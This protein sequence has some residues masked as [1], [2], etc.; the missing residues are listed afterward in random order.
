M[1]E[2][3]KNKINLKL[4]R[5]I[6][7]FCVVSVSLTIGLVTGININKIVSNNHNGNNQSTSLAD[8]LANFLK[9]NW[10]S[11]I[12]YGK[13][14][15]EDV[16]IAQFIGALSTSKDTMLDS[17][18]FLI[19]NES[20]SSTSGIVKGKLGATFTNY[21][22]LPLITK[23]EDNAACKGYLNV[24]DIVVGLSKPD[25]KNNY[26]HYSIFD[27]DITFSGL[28]EQGLGLPGQEEI[29]TIARQVDENSFKYIDYKITLKAPSYTSIAYL[30]KE[31]I[32]NTIMVKLDGFVHDDESSYGTSEQ[33][34]QIL[35]KNIAKNLILDLRGNG[36]GD[37][38]SAIDVAD[39][40]LDNDLVVASL[41]Y[42]NGKRSSY[43]SD[44]DLKY[45]YDNIVILQD[46]GT[47]SASE[48]LISALLHYLPET[49]TLVGQKSYGKGICQSTT[50][51]M[52]GKYQLKYTI[53]KWLRPDNTWIGM[54]DAF[55]DGE[56][57]FYPESQNMVY[58]TKTYNMMASVN[59]YLNRNGITFYKENDLENDA[60]VIDSVASQNQLFFEVYN[61][62]YS[63]NIRTDMY[64]DQS[65]KD[66]LVEY[67][68][69][70]NIN[71]TGNMDEDTLVSFTF[72]YYNQYQNY[73]NSY[74]EVAKNIIG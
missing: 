12:Y 4:K 61:L 60:F 14:V 32:S 41:E 48:I 2:N 35:D 26:T 18:T 34:K 16:L 71:Q 47:A 7:C 69:L 73:M 5:L 15:D 28:F 9:N 11:E 33:L 10:Y 22:G 50:S 43:V 19:E 3:K 64:F 53:A 30:E 68:T 37:V 40:F 62:L 24:G 46:G 36:G 8:E 27:K 66:A 38:V 57:G 63:K 54:T 17:Y 6:I 31:N 1:E 44:D 52:Q 51:V 39:L 59:S 29:V 74:L 25:S 56:F 42:K 20:T 70:K 45:E 55:I 72:D 49:V 58:S 21:Y 13:D 67:Q 65:C 23:I